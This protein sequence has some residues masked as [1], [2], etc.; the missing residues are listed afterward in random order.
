MFLSNRDTSVMAVL[1][2][3]EP[4]MMSGVRRPQQSDEQRNARRHVCLLSRTLQ[5]ANDASRLSCSV[6]TSHGLRSRF[7]SKFARV[8]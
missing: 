4:P 3:L 8:I 6:P 2:V 5:R 7:E 1:P